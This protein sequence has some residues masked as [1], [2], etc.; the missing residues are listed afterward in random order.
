M[1]RRVRFCILLATV[2]VAG[3]GGD[4]D[5]GDAGEPV[6]DAGQRD[7]ATPLDGG[8][9]PDSGG[10]EDAGSEPDGGAPATL[11]V[12]RWGDR[13]YGQALAMSRIDRELWI[14]TS[15]VIDPSLGETAPVRSALLRLDLDDGALR[16]FEAELPP[17]PHWSGTSGPTP[18]A[19][20][21]GDGTRRI[22]AARTGLLVI[23]GDALTAH[24]LLVAGTSASP[25][26]LAIDRAGGRASLWASTDLGLVELDPDTLSVRSSVAAD[27]LGGVPGSLA[28]DPA[29]GAVYAAV[30]ADTGASQV[31]RVLG[32]ELARLH[33]GEGGAPNGMVGDVVFSEAWGGA[34]IA[35]ASWDPSTGGVA[36]WDGTDVRAIAVEGTLSL[37]ARG[38][39]VAFGAS[40]LA[41]D[42]GVLV[43]GGRIHAT[44][45]IG[46]LEGGGIAWLDLSDPSV[47][48]PP[49]Y[50]LS[51]STSDVRGDVVTAAAFDPVDGR[52]YLGLQQPCNERQIG[53]VGVQAIWFER[54]EP[55]F[56]LP[57]LSVVRDVQ[58]VDGELWVGVRD[59]NVG[60][61][62]DAVAVHVG[63]ARVDGS[64]AGQAPSVRGWRPTRTSVTEIAMRDRDWRVVAG[65]REELFVGSESGGLLVSPAIELGTSLWPE[66]VEWENDRTFWIA[67]RTSHSAG[68]PPHVADVGPRGAARVVLNDAGSIESVTQYVRLDRD[69]TPGVITGLPSAEVYDVVLDAAGQVY[70]VCGTE[71]LIGTYDRVPR[72]EFRLDGQLRRGGVVRIEADGSI[73]MIAGPGVAPDGRAGAFAPDGTLYVLDAERGLLR[74]TASGFEVVE[75]PGVPEGS[76]GQSLWIGEGTDL[77]AGYDTGAFVRIGD[78]QIFLGDVGFVWN[79]DASGEV[80]LLGTDRGLVRVSPEGVEDHGEPAPLPGDAPPFVGAEPPPP[81]PPPGDAG[82][83]L[84]E[85]QVC[86]T[87]PTACCPGLFCS[88]LGIV[89]TCARL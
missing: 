12:E 16:V 18:T 6:V 83:C 2:Y 25:T 82:M 31:V 13:I 63:Y 15:A 74:Q 29:S 44:G 41:L 64:R 81:P 32:T 37:A 40:K 47:V 73:T 5:D 61:S 59:E 78:A 46:I 76:I 34:I 60:V 51:T 21:V 69:G 38:E 75:L 79:V 66:D 80:I 62:C 57:I 65:F 7:A 52:T 35:F 1:G 39:P 68:D 8:E 56:E 87:D 89:Q 17:A 33:P 54:G 3:C 24:P 11:N 55:R 36:L 70:L 26:H 84:T 67:G 10:D 77:V 50:G 22:A 23:E 49:I 53:N 86:R 85:G 88:S 72:D 48:D 9:A 43:V 45:P 30:H 42:G 27:A 14:G 20:V 28:I 4:G 58:R 71:R 19:S